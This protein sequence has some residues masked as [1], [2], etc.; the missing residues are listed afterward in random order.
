MNEK[1]Y[2]KQFTMTGSV[3]DY[4]RYRSFT[5]HQSEQ[6]SGQSDPC[7]ECRDGE[8][9]AGLRGGNRDRTEGGSYGRIR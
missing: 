4:L 3:E 6:G 5:E 1:N 7:K 8:I 9:H 2:W